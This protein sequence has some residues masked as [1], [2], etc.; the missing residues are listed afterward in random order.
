MKK[1]LMVIPLVFLLC[2][3]FG[4]QKGHELAAAQ[5]TEEEKAEV[6]ASIEQAFSEYVEA[7][8]QMDWDKTLQFFIDSDDLVFAANGSIVTGKNSFVMAHN[9]V[10]DTVK[11]FNSFETPNKY[12]Y[13]LS[14]DSAVLTI[15]FNESF[16]LSP[17]DVA[18]THGSFVYVFHRINGDWKIVHAGGT[19]VP[20]TE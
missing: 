4:C 2:F 18:R 5:I 13:I 10:T 3:T 19:I 7:T 17:D 6:A 16:T 15:E 20:I 14:R 8:L 1:Q 12:I 11:E 9:Q